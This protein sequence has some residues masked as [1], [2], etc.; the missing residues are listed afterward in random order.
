MSRATTGV[1]AMRST[2][3]SKFWCGRKRARP[4]TLPRRPLI[5]THLPT[6][7][8]T[9]ICA[10]IS[11]GPL[12]CCVVR[13][14]GSQDSSSAQ[15]LKSRFSIIRTGSKYASGKCLML[16]NRSDFGASPMRPFHRTRN[17]NRKPNGQSR[18]SS[19]S[20]SIDRPTRAGRLRHHPRPSCS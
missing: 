12:V 19:R 11:R 13:S 17:I 3:I 4:A 8:R 10:R 1:K 18:F 6:T 16:P 9:R 15:S 2:L 5:P 20:L 7:L 14:S